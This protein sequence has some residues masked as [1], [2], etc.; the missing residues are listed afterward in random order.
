MSLIDLFRD[1]RAFASCCLWQH[2]CENHCVD[3]KR[4]LGLFHVSHAQGNLLSGGQRHAG[5][6][7]V[8][9]G[10]FGSQHFAQMLV[11][12]IQGAIRH[13]IKQALYFFQTEIRHQPVRHI[14]L[15]R[16]HARLT[17]GQVEA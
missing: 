9:S 2:P 7:T 4:F 12:R 15:Q 1:F 3:E 16:Q 5:K 8:D 14:R 13:G 17:V 10:F 11:V 6:C